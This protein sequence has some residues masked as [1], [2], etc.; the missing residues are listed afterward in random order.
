MLRER[1]R[2]FDKVSSGSKYFLLLLLLLVVPSL[3]TNF[4]PPYEIC[5]PIHCSS[6]V[7]LYAVYCTVLYTPQPLLLLLFLLLKAAK[8]TKKREKRKDLYF[9]LIY[10]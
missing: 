2:L 1:E 9:F 4:Y 10:S 6:I 5:F 7:S 3:L 8:L